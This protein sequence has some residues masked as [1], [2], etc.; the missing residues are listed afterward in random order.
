MTP[1]GQPVGQC[2]QC[3]LLEERR[4]RG[5]ACQVIGKLGLAVSGVH[6]LAARPL[7]PG[8]PPGQLVGRDRDTTHDDIRLTKLP[9]DTPVESTCCLLITAHT[10]RGNEDFARPA[11]EPRL[12]W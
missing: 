12:A 5:R 10:S 11:L 2:G 3:A 8:E 6:R 1:R 7:G 9:C 4:Q